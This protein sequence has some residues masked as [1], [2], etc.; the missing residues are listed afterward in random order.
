MGFDSHQTSVM[1][2]SVSRRRLDQENST[3]EDKGLLLP[4]VIVVNR[5]HVDLLRVEI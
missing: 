4:S 2:D 1:S 5:N 3:V